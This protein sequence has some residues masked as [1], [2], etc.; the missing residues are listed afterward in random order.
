MNNI[1]R[2]STPCVNARSEVNSVNFIK[3]EGL[4]VLLDYKP[5]VIGITEIWEQPNSFGQYKCLPGCIFVSNG[6][7]QKEVKLDYT[8]KIA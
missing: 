8:L 3:L 5:D 1:Y 7:L 4:I 2:F 6:K